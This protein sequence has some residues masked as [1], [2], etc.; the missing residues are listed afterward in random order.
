MIES[1]HG[2]AKALVHLIAH[3]GAPFVLAH[4]NPPHI[5]GPFTDRETALRH[6]EKCR[7]SRELFP[8]NNFVEQREKGSPPYQCNLLECNGNMKS[9]YLGPNKMSCPWGCTDGTKDNSVLVV[10]FL[11]KCENP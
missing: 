11:A 6:F 2:D 8:E 9:A 7:K 5:C 3:D 4:P 1:M 10:S